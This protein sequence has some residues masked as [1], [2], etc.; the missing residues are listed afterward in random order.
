MSAEVVMPQLLVSTASTVRRMGA[1]VAVFMARLR[2]GALE[3]PRA[4]RV[5]GPLVAEETRPA[6]PAARPAIAVGQWS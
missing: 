4:A 1:V 2:D 5:G 3:V 6:A